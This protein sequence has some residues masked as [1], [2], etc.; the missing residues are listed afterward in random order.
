MEHHS[1]LN[2]YKGMIQYILDSTHYTLKNIAQL[3]H[4]SLD[5]I[6]MIYCHNALPGSFNSE[7][8]LMKL[9]QIILEINEK[10]QHSTING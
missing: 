5:A 7:I 3:S 4:S 10:R 1:K 6:R 9:Y 8:E 2:I